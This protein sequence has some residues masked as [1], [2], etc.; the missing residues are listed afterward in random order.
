MN[1]YD[2][3]RFQRNYSIY[4]SSKPVIEKQVKLKSIRIRKPKVIIIKP[5]LPKGVIP[6][7]DLDLALEIIFIITLTYDSRYRYS[8]TFNLYFGFAQYVAKSKLFP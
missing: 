6:L 4:S 1:E 5:M 3:F 2:R 8:L 7:K